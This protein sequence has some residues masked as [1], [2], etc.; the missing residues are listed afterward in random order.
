MT[1][2]KNLMAMIAANNRSARAYSHTRQIQKPEDLGELKF[3]LELNKLPFKDISLN[4]NIFLLY[5]DDEDN[6]IG[7]AGL[8]IY[9]EAGLIRSIAVSSKDRGKKLGTKIVDEML[10]LAR[11]K[12]LRSVF[13][14]T[15]TANEF[16]LKV[17]FQDFSRHDVPEAVKNSSEFS[18]V[19]PASAKCMAF[20]FY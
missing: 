9:G 4:G 20:R 8:E 15:E 14:L 1:Y 2:L 7:S 5:Y 11:T 3:F 19:C 16:F 6:V 10:L 18:L 12:N 17:G 13:L